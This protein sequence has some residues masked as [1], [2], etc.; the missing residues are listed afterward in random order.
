MCSQQ[1]FN[2]D[3]WLTISHAHIN[4]SR[5]FKQHNFLPVMCPFLAQEW[6]LSSRVIP[7]FA[8][9]ALS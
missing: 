1:P 2:H 6:I 3:I 7:V 4:H 8:I 5:K 9:L